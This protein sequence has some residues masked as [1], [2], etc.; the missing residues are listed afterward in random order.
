MYRR[1]V[2]DFN[3]KEAKGQNKNKIAD[4]HVENLNEKEIEKELKYIYGKIII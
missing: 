2:L 1:K 3:F 4:K